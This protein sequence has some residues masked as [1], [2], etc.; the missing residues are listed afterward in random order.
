M[1]E[2][3]QERWDEALRSLR[4][5]PLDESLAAEARAVV[6][7][8]IRRE[9]R[10]RWA[11]MA[12]AAALVLAAGLT[13]ARRDAPPNETARTVP[14]R[15]AAPAVVGQ[16]DGLRRPV[17]PPKRVARKETARPVEIARAVEAPR[18][19]EAARPVETARGVEAAR[20]VEM[21]R[22]PMKIHMLT[23]DPDLVIIWLAGEEGDLDE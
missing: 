4:D 12:T 22:E 14:P 2:R 5:E 7:G 21:A 9:R 23:D 20:A 13:L 17:R 6:L 18:S 19:V 11:W 10:M 15:S 1:N 3:E 8:R 16:A